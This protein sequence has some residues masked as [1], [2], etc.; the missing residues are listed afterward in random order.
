MITKTLIAAIALTV[1]ASILPAH[2]KQPAGKCA[3]FKDKADLAVCQTHGP[4]K[5][6]K[7]IKCLNDGIPA[8]AVYSVPRDLPD[9]YK[10]YR[11]CDSFLRR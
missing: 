9:L 11:E 4:E 5:A 6:A 8:D 2:A 1:T 10:T 3:A 7:F